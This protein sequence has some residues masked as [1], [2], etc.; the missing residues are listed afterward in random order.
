MVFGQTTARTLLCLALPT[1]NN[2]VSF[3]KMATSTTSVGMPPIVTPEGKKALEL[4]LF[5]GG[6]SPNGHKAA[7][8]FEELR[9]AYGKEFDYS[10]KTIESRKK[11]H[12]SAEF[13]K[14][15]P[16]NKIP[17]L[18]HTLPSGHTARI[19]ESSAILSYITTSFDPD[20]KLS[21]ST[22]S[23]HYGEQLS[24]LFWGPGN[25]TPTFMEAV[26]YNWLDVKVPH[27]SER[28]GKEAARVIGVI[29][30][31]LEEE[32]GREYLVGDGKGTFSVAD[33]S[34]FP[35]VRGMFA[36]GGLPQGDLKKWPHVAEWLGRIQSRPTVQ[37][38]LTTGQ[39]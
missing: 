7:I 38:G 20:H 18:L 33:I 30:Q 9:N 23:P 3:R 6:G 37:A 31:R 32:G 13:S 35:L 22:S 21:F 11:E 14:V 1:L 16:N 4:Y 5:V 26:H 28:V 17:A 24:W 25:L 39:R 36:F 19:F 34:L 8:L 15:N 2:C 12:F 10:L 27:A 29:N